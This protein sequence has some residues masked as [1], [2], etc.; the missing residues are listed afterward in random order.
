M[1]QANLEITPITTNQ[2][3][4]AAIAVTARMDTVSDL[5]ERFDERQD[6][7]GI[8]SCTI[9]MTGL[10]QEKKDLTKNIVQNPKDQHSPGEWEET[11][12]R[13]RKMME[14]AAHRPDEVRYRAGGPGHPE[15]SGGQ[16]AA[17][18]LAGNII[19]ALASIAAAGR[20][21]QIMADAGEEDEARWAAFGIAQGMAHSTP[22]WEDME[23]AME[24]PEWTSAPG[25]RDEIRRVMCGC[26]DHPQ[27]PA[28]PLRTQARDLC[29]EYGIEHP[30]EEAL[31]RPGV[32][33]DLTLSRDPGRRYQLSLEIGAPDEGF[34]DIVMFRY[35]DETYVQ[36][37][38]EPFP[39]GFP[40]PTALEIAREFLRM[41]AEPGRQPQGADWRGHRETGLSAAR[42]AQAGLHDLGPLRR[43][44]PPHRP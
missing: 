13:A 41:C 4:V 19:A 9:A 32:I 34:V 17:A 35:R 36:A 42:A 29:R 14:T 31:D 44:R 8:V 12:A 23:D 37:V 18:G 33:S 22:A 40:G 1:A 11:H 6:V 10:V 2:L 38:G 28:G 30:S 24:R 27:N 25:V 39:R 3:R 20:L 16:V 43:G 15:P 7:T 5:A 21:G 26:E